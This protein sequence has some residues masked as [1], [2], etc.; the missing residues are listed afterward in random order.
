MSP[1]ASGHSVLLR[2]CVAALLMVLAGCVA[3]RLHRTGMSL[4]EKGR[5]EEGLN[6]LEGS[7]KK[8][9]GDIKRR[10]SFY[11]TRDG[12]I[13]QL[14]Q[15]AEKA[16]AAGDVQ[17]A[18]ALYRRALVIAP[19]DFRITDGI[20]ALEKRS[21]HEDLLKRAEAALESGDLDEADDIAQ[22]VLADYAADARAQSV[23]AQA[24]RARAKRAVVSPQLQSRLTKPVTLEFRDAA[25]KMVFDVLS[26]ASGLNFILDK[27]IRSDTRIT[28]YVRN[29]AVEDAI[30]LILVQSQLEK[31]VLSD[32]TVLVY[33]NTPQKVREYQDLVIRSFYLVN[34]DAKETANLLK[35]IL[36]VKDIQVDDRLNMIFLRD[37]PDTVRLAEKLIRNQDLA[38]PEVVLEMEV[39]EIN[40]TRAVELGMS[41]PDTF[42]WLVP[43]PNKI[44]LDQLPF[45]QRRSTDRIGINASTVLRMKQ[46]NGVANLLSNPRI[47]VKNREQARVLVGDRVPIITATVTPGAVNPVT[48]ETISYLDV[49]LKLDVQPVILLDD[50]V[51][52]KVMLEVST[53]GDSVK[54]NS[55]SVAYRV[56]TRTVA[57]SLR[58]R[59]GETQVLMGLIR[60]EER[61]SAGGVPGLMSLP[62]IGRLFSVPKNEKQKTEIVLS[63]TP[64][65]VRNVRRPQPHELEF[66]SG[67]EASMKSG[68]PV[69]QSDAAASGTSPRAASEGRQD[70]T[71]APA[72]GAGPTQTPVGPDAA[73]AQT[74][75]GPDVGAESGVA[76]APEPIQPVRFEWS[77]P[78]HAR[79]GETFVVSVTA[80]APSPLL[81]AALS[82]KFDP[83]VLEVV[84]VA[85]GD[86]LKQGDAQPQFDYTTDA[87]GGRIAVSVSRE[88]LGALQGQGRLFNVTFKV[89]VA[90]EKSQ[91]Q[92]TSMS[93][94]GADNTP[95]PFSMSGPL[96]LSLVP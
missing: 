21:V 25:V 12:V 51:S 49:G 7:V 45:E 94:V 68:H 71:P 56:G 59:D 26:R 27:E 73:A 3:Q 38:E 57:T 90:S 70:A 84:E 17:T 48:T 67:T 82:L 10:M 62:L 46:D 91:L 32:N 18:A 95:I 13:E 4:I 92:I 14:R 33:P 89:K 43:D 41:W 9:T 93:P 72:A 5:Y 1:G 19:H 44:T 79:V 20:R 78:E 6:K 61:G 58:M 54:T 60:D 96:T 63:I 39:M 88:G 74:P 69:F 8:D 23:R 53:L 24:E 66:W 52:I 85:E 37:T 11:A 47:R 22:K 75:V 31:K 55:G 80:N 15:D 50:D 64:R 16:K 40:R 87:L 86:L 81:S 42:T 35:N 30:D 83:N 29:V 76:Q 77:A 28:I 36:K 34:S 65:I 2:C